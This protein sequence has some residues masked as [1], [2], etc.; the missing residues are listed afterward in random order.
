MRL[1]LMFV[2]GLL[3]IEAGLLGNPGSMLGSIIDPANM[4]DTSSAST[5]TSSAP[6]APAP[7]ALGGLP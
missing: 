5:S 3:L 2:L 6:A 4:Q 7:P 1:V